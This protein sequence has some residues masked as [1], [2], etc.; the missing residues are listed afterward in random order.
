MFQILG[1]SLIT[2]QSRALGIPLVSVPSKGEK[3]DELEDL[4]TAIKQAQKRYQI[5][6]IVSGAI[7]SNYQASRIQR[8]CHELGLWCFCPLWQRPRSLYLQ[9]LV[10]SGFS[11]ILLGVF[12][13]P[14]TKQDVGTLLTPS[15][16][17]HLKKLED[18]YGIHQALEGGEAETFVLDGPIYRQQIRLESYEIIAE[19]ENAAYMTQIK[20]KLDKK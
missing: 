13:Y 8:L 14:L 5:E 6:G 4:R 1:N 9:E 16:A 12:S 18:Q 11:I 15:Y 7:E 20:A 19:A 3:E 2:L 10:D 17:E